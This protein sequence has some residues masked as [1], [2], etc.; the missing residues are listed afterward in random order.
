[1][2]TSSRVLRAHDLHVGFKYPVLSAV[3]LDIPIGVWWMLLGPNGC[4]KT[5]LLDTLAGRLPAL[6]GDIEIGG[7]SIGKNPLPAKRSLGYA[8][9]PDRLPKR[10]TGRECL[11]V[12]AGING[13]NT[14]SE[15]VQTLIGEWNF[16][17][18]LQKF[19]D[20]MSLGMRQKLG[21][22]LA[23]AGQPKIVITDESLNGLDP[24]SALKLKRFLQTQVQRH[25]FSVLM[26]THALDV[27]EQYADAALVCDQGR[28]A[29]SLSR[30][31]LDQADGRL[32]QFIAERLAHD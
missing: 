14:D 4:G 30:H 13:N 17:R 31:D 11:N 25:R 6:T 5:T 12:F 1:M 26:A 15:H 3:N 20:R 19:V 23:L 16:D 27:V 7:Y 28:V 32:D 10:L 8:L 29:L 21:I 18:D 22:L 9:P 2:N 24:S